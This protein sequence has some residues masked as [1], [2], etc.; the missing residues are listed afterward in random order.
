MNR[1]DKKLYNF[2]FFQVGV[3]SYLGE[4]G[5]IEPSKPLHPRALSGVRGVVLHVSPKESVRICSKRLF[6]VDNGG[7]FPVLVW[8]GLETRV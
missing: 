7:T 3:P 6:P 2:S 8:I 5:R 1:R 4:G